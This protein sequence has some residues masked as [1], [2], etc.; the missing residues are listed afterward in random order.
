MFLVPAS[1]GLIHYLMTFIPYAIPVGIPVAVGIVYV[2]M[3][4]YGNIGWQSIRA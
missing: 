1:L 4:A 3:K 2:G